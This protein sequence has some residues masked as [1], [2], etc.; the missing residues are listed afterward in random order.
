MEFGVDDSALARDYAH[1]AANWNKS[2]KMLREY[3]HI[4]WDWNGT[5]LDDAWLCV[6]VCNEMLS[7]RGKR[8][9]TLEQYQAN[10]DF[11]VKDFYPKAGFDFAVE[12]FEVLAREYVDKYNSRRFECK[13]RENALAVLNSIADRGLSQ[14]LLSAY[15]KARLDEAVDFF[16]IRRF[17]TEVIGLQDHHAVGK[18]EEGRLLIEKS[19]F[20]PAEILLI[21]DTVH[22]YEVAEAVGIDCILIPSGHNSK[23]RLE[24]CGVMVM[25]S[26]AKLLQD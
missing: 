6:E 5:L 20:R 4:I 16:D 24:S 2:N 23:E 19:G 10:F 17:F 7:A 9:M 14:S 21:G 3:R 1:S 8:A 12:P 18:V 13:L 26:L 25:D 11:P 15:H 22:D